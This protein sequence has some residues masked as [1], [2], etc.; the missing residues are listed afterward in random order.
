MILSISFTI[1]LSLARFFFSL[2]YTVVVHSRRFCA[3]LQPRRLTHR[4]LSGAEQS[5]YYTILHNFLLIL[6]PS[7]HFFHSR[8]SLLMYLDLI[9]YPYRMVAESTEALC[10]S[11]RARKQQRIYVIIHG[12]KENEKNLIYELIFSMFDA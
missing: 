4:R 8:L 10:T 1:S 6:A 2:P 11:E 5:K 7:F 3:E 12:T 9:S